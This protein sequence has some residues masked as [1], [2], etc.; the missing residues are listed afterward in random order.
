MIDRVCSARFANGAR[1]G[2]TGAMTGAMTVRTAARID[3]YS[4]VAGAG[5]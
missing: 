3:G 5:Y 2:P 1:I 4:V